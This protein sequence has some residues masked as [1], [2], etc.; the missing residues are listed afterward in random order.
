MRDTIL[1]I[2]VVLMLPTAALGQEGAPIA[3]PEPI[4]FRPVVDQLIDRV[5]LPGYAEL[6]AAS[7][8][9]TDAMAALC[10]APGS[11]TLAD[12]RTAFANLAVAWSRVEM[13][14][15]GPARAENRYERMFFWPDRRGLGLRQVQAIM[16]DEDPTATDVDTLRG[17]SVAVQGLLA[18]EYVLFGTDSDT[19]ADTSP[20]GYRCRYGHAIAG[21]IAANAAEMRDGWTAPDGY[22]AIMRDPGAANPVYRSHGEVVQDILRSAREQIQIVRD[23]KLA[24]PLG[25][26]PAAAIPTQAPFWRSNLTIPTIRAN[27][28]AVSSL[29]DP[30]GIGAI[31][32]TGADWMGGSLQFELAS[33]NAA[34]ATLKGTGLDWESTVRS[35]EGYEKLA[36]TLIP[37]GSAF[38]LLEQRIPAALGLTAGFNT[39]DGD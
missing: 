18:L 2:A 6:A 14:R 29:I 24:R 10:A 25:D 26:S 38:A 5:I 33:A 7:V 39:L 30:G 9:T 28:D 23:I 34:L 21:A 19:L 15:M 12:S 20:D 37:L 27:I 36:Y 17:K 8:T 4:A 32:P 1:A 3:P 31:L 35:V 22:A 16:A 13:F 11:D